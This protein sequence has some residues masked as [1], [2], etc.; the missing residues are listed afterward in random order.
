[1]LIIHLITVDTF[2]SSA[3]VL[4]CYAQKLKTLNVDIHLSLVQNFSFY[5]TEKSVKSV[6]PMWDILA[7]L[8]NMRIKLTYKHYLGEIQNLNVTT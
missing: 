8:R 6:E 3:L 5:P 2:T 1:M 7:V 4:V